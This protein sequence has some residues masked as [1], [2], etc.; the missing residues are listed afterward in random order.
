MTTQTSAKFKIVNNGK[1][2]KLLSSQL[3]TNKQIA[4]VR[5]LSCNALDAHTLNKQTKPFEL[6][7]DYDNFIIKDY[8]PG[9]SH[10]QMMI[11][12]PSYGDSTKE[13]SDEAVGGLGLGS[14]TPFSLCF[15]LTTELSPLK[16]L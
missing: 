8:G 11:L 16:S 15:S 14:K 1:M 9:L 7:I 12:Y 2:F 6:L 3:Y 4:I 13:E 10:E 5:E